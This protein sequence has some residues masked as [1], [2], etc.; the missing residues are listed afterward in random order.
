[1]HYWIW[2]EFKPAISEWEIFIS[3]PDMYAVSVR[4]TFLQ[5]L[6]PCHSFQPQ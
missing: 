6:T 5:V 2:G 1:M 3:A 4:Y